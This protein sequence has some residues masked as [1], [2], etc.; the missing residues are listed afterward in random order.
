MG[1]WGGYDSDLSLDQTSLQ[2]YQ[3]MSYKINP[4]W[5]LSIGYRRQYLKMESNKIKINV[6]TEGPALGVSYQF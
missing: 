1:S 4:A 2:W 3:A 6:N 5:I